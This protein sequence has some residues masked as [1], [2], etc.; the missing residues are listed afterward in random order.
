MWEPV[1]SYILSHT[2]YRTF[3]YFIL[4]TS[5][6]FVYFL[7]AILICRLPIEDQHSFM[8]RCILFYLI[9]VQNKI[10]IF[11]CICVLCIVIGLETENL[12]YKIL[13]IYLKA[14]NLNL[15]RYINKR[16]E[17]RKYVGNV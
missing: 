8:S 11:S 3:I 15:N 1:F 10:C 4:I 12:I 13:N 6:F 14:A 9:H 17:N 16:D 5:S 7:F 2:D